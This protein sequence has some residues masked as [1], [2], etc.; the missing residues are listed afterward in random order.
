M[1]KD[2]NKCPS[3][4]IISSAVE[5][6]EKSMY[7]LLEIYDSYISKASLRP[8]FD[9]YGNVYMTVDMELK[10]QIREALLQMIYDFE[11][12]IK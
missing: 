4:Y 11:L 5:G 2:V 10:G 3:Y 8:L 6:N 7:K 12:N 1:V 9:S